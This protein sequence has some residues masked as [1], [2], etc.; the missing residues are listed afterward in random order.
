MTRAYFSA[1]CA[2]LLLETLD[3]NIS[4]TF[5][6]ILNFS[7]AKGGSINNTNIIFKHIIL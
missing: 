3:V 7:S 5:F 1:A 2:F 6:P 4:P